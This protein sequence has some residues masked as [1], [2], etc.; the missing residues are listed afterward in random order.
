[1]HARRNFTRTSSDPLRILQIGAGSMGTRRLR[2]L[3]QRA[4]VTVALYDQ[5]ADRRERAQKRFGIATFGRWDEAVAWDPQAL[6]ISTPPSTK[7]PYIDFALKRRL[8]H[9]S[10]ADIRTYGAA[11][12]SRKAPKLVS[13]PSATIRLLP[14]IQGLGQL[15]REELGSI[16]SYQLALGTYMPGWHPTEGREYYARHRDTNPA[17]EMICFELTW[18]DAVF[19]PAVAVAG[20]FEKFGPLPGR[21]EDTWSMQLRLKSGGIGQITS[22]MACPRDFLRGHCLGSNG[23]ASWNVTTGEVWIQTTKDTATRCYNF[24]S[25]AATLEPMY[26]VE[27]N[28][29]VDA[30]QGKKTWPQSYTLSQ[31]VMATLA[32]AEKSAVTGRWV[33]VDPRIEPLQSPP[34]L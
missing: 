5:R 25:T 27:I 31:Q 12:R 13:A 11:P 30:I 32:A 4:D 34:T 21:T 3:H 1:M 28:T 9:F 23:W 20:H 16:L 2:D 18:L 7:G 6:I 29:F 26:A 22:A 14:V 8:H 10:E 19:G 33:N 15:V 17:R 24:G